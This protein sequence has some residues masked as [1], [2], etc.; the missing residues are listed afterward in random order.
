MNTDYEDNTVKATLHTDKS[1]R[2][3]PKFPSPT[4]SNKG[5]VAAV[6]EATEIGC[7][8]KTRAAFSQEEADR[9]FYRQCEITVRQQAEDRARAGKEKEKNPQEDIRVT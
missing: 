4:R 9:E 2:D 5:K 6:E 1:V 3:T 8:K 7:V